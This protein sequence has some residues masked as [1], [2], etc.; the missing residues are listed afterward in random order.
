VSGEQA[1]EADISGTTFDHIGDRSIAEAS[2]SRTAMPI[3]APESRPSLD[4]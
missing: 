4:T 2:R 3:N 1:V